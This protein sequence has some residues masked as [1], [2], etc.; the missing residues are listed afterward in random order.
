M[1]LRVGFFKNINKIDKGLTR[2]IS[3]I[4]SNERRDTTTNATE[5]KRIMILLRT[6]TLEQIG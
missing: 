3:N 6:I 1:K 2:E 4:C 5:I